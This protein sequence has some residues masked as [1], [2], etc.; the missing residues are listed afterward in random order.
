V[1]EAWLQARYFLPNVKDFVLTLPL[2]CS[3]IYANSMIM[4]QAILF[5]STQRQ[6]M[7]WSF[8]TPRRLALMAGGSLVLMALAAGFAYGYVLSGLTVAGDAAATAQNL[9][10]HAGRFY[11]GLAA[12]GLIALLDL[13]VA[14]ALGRFFRPVHRRMAQVS[15]KLRVIYT[16]FLAVAIWQLVGIAGWISQGQAPVEDIATALASFE[17]IWG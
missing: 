12:W 1:H 3:Q 8:F 7:P 4:L 10:A 2:P 11:G 9:L 15:A 6:G 16:G 13:I 14:W 17:A 5:P